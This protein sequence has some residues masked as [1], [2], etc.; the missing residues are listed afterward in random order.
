MSAAHH[1]FTSFTA[2]NLAAREQTQNEVENYLYAV[3]HELSAPLKTVK[4]YIDFLNHMNVFQESQFREYLAKIEQQMERMDSQV[5]DLLALSGITIR[6]PVYEQFALADVVQDVLTDVEENFYDQAVKENFDAPGRQINVRIDSV[7]VLYADKSLIRMVVQKLVENAVKFS[8]H[9]EVA[10]IEIG[11][12]KS[13]KGARF[14]VKDN[15]AGFS[16]D[17]YPQLFRFCSRLHSRQEFP[18]NGIGLSIAKQ[19]VDLHCGRIWAEAKPG[20]GAT[21]YV[22]IPWVER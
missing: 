6:K 7:P 20:V 4:M 17:D 16:M 5:S 18:G 12:D 1:H 11:G 8:R 10:E 19:I 3:A 9:K 15:G 2:G 14:F 22:L 13:P 21:F